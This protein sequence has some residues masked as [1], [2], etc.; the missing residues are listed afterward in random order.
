MTEG[1]FKEIYHTDSDDPELKRKALLEMATY[2]RDML[3][4]E[5]RLV[6][7]R[8]KW[9]LTLNGFLFAAFGIIL[10]YYNGSHG[11]LIS[12]S[13]VFSVVGC[14]LAL[15][16]FRDGLNGADKAG[17]LL[18]ER[19]E[20]FLKTFFNYQI[21]NHAFNEE[22]FTPPIGGLVSEGDKYIKRLQDAK[23]GK[24]SLG[25]LPLLM[26]GAWIALFIV[27]LIFNAVPCLRPSVSKCPVCPAV[28]ALQDGAASPITTTTNYGSLNLNV[29]INP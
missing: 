18:L 26:T 29:E 13:L 3:D 24:L 12:I 25:D 9:F 17:V 5:N 4:H 1:N 16:I 6:D 7:Y 21:T 23:D 28:C 27:V 10:A 15:K 14:I 20:K 2:Y 8:T 22:F 19:W 11:F